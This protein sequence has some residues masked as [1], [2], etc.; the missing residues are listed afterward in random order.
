MKREAIT[1]SEVKELLH[2][3]PLT[4][5]FTRKVS[6]GG[7]YG[8]AVGSVAGTLND[9][10]YVLI[11]LKSLQYRAHRLAWL[12]MTGKW[13]EFEIDHKDGIRTNNCWENLRDVT[14]KVN[15]QNARKAR[16]NSKTGLLGSS[17]NMRDKRFVARIRVG[18]KYQSLGGFDSAELAH[19]A[20]LTAKRQ[21]HVGCTI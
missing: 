3:E 17:W 21:L 14:G 9:G 19:A 20:Y 10:G 13:P 18:C 1:H 6:T 4:G 2:Y 11:S 12:Y 7:R 16:K 15:V 8:S 5:I